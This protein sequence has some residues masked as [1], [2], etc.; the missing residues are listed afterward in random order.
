MGQSENSAIVIGAGLAGLSTAASLAAM[1]WQVTV[2]E[3]YSVVGGST[4]AFRRKNRWEWEVGVHHLGDCG[5]SGDMPTVLRGLGIGPDHLEFRKMDDNGFDR[6]LLPDGMVFETPSDWG[7]WERRLGEAFPA[8][9]DTIGRF[10]TAVQAVSAAIDRGP[11][12]QSLGGLVKA[13]ARM[14]RHAPMAMLPTTRVLNMLGMSDH[15]QILV[16]VAASG[17][18]NVPP[19]RLSFA[20]FSQ[21]YKAFIEGGSWFPRGGGQM[22]SA[23]VLHSL[24]HSGGDVRTNEFVDRILVEHGRATGVTTMSGLTLRAD[25][26]VSTVDLKK[27]YNDLLPAGSMPKS[28]YKRVNRY[29]MSSA[30][31]NTFL[32]VDVDIARLY[33]NR[34]TFVVPKW[35]GLDEIDRLSAYQPGDTTS[36]WLDRLV[37]SLGAYVHCSNVKD[38]DNPHYAPAGSSS[39]EVMF[40]FRCDYRLWGVDPSSQRGHEYRDDDAYGEAKQRLTDAMISMAE[41]AYPEITGKIAHQESATP[42]TQERFTQS[43]L[44]TPYGIEFNNAQMGFRRPGATTS[45]KG[46][47]L[48]GASCRPGPA[49]EGVLLSGLQT[50]G[51]ITGRD[52]LN[53]FR[54][55]RYLIGEKALPPIDLTTWDPLTFARARQQP[56][57]TC[58][59][60][61]HS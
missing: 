38:P 23:T 35:I 43:T 57:L 36:S 7:L 32:G 46:L 2:L 28:D 59:V 19:S 58:V 24:L 52:L 18:L 44:G 1:G 29:R 27:T 11:T 40:P 41:I 20:A 4:H 54:R 49:T 26:V 10:V 9:R 5:P 3:Q 31:F 17:S 56:D 53:D 6:Y 60:S 45:L 22:L 8:E 48:A 34:D 30:F 61:G 50:V 42:L 25:V 39:L 33:P 55:G 37:P 14:G 13:G 47:F 15:L 16:T 21:F 51:A 12:S